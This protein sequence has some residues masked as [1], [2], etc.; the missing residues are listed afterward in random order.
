M[1]VLYIEAPYSTC[2][3]RSMFRLYLFSFKKET[4][5]ASLLII[6][7]YTLTSVDFPKKIVCHN[8]SLFIPGFSDILGY[9]ILL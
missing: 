4:A 1:T 7:S 5:V 8:V 6:E 9:Q 2:V 3:W